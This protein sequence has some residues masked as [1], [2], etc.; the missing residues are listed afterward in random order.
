[1]GDIAAL[2]QSAP[3]VLQVREVDLRVPSPGCYQNAEGDVRL[4]RRA[5]PRLKALRV[6]KLPVERL[7]R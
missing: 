2:V 1:M 5:I 3:G 7:G 4:P 6:E